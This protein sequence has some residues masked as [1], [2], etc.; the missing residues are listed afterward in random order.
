MENAFLSDEAINIVVTRLP[1]GSFKSLSPPLTIVKKSFDTAEVCFL[2]SHH[3]DHHR[4][5]SSRS[6]SEIAFNLPTVQVNPD[7]YLPSVMTC[8]NYLKLPDYSTKV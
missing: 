1:I 7:D 2:Q 8:A 5:S 4:R 3:H 6:S